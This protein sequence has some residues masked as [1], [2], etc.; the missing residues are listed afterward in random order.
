MTTFVTPED[1]RRILDGYAAEGVT[2][3]GHTPSEPAAAARRD[4]VPPP[5]D[6]DAPPTG[7]H[8][9]RNGQA[10]KPK[11]DGV[12]IVL[13][14]AADVRPERVRWAW[15]GRIPAG[16]VT[17]MVGKPK[18]GKSTIACHVVAGLSRGTLDGDLLG[19]PLHVVF[20]SAEDSTAHTLVPRLIAARADLRRVHF[21]TLKRDGVPDGIEL[22]DDADRL[23]AAVERV[24]AGVIVVDPLAA[25]LAGGVDSHRDAPMRRAM[26]PLHRMAEERGVTSIALAHTNKGQ[27]GDVHDRTGGSRAM[28]AA[29]RSLLLA[30]EHPDDDGSCVLV[31]AACNVGVEAPTLRYRVT[32][33]PIELHDRTPG[34]AAA[35]EWLGEAPE[36]RDHTVL[37]TRADDTEERSARVT[38]EAWLRDVLAEGPV[39]AKDVRRLAREDGIADRTLDRAKTN[40]KVQSKREGGLGAEGKWMWSL[41]DDAAIPNSANEPLSTPPPERG[42]DSVL[43]PDGGDVSEDRED[44]SSRRPPAPRPRSGGRLPSLTADERGAMTVAR[45][46][47]ARPCIRCRRP[48]AMRLADGQPHCMDCGDTQ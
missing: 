36:V 34:E 27:G 43:R 30:G 23:A 12:E 18:V 46:G 4:D 28:T 37:A 33:Q 20:L 32:S 17:L 6:A 24:N 13:T 21:L 26:A 16:M 5:G 1:Q 15:A 25:H 8:P 3:N 41:P 10:G 40:A 2:P 39:A 38:T 47:I 42:G 29:P 7:G 19:E 14:T 31:H 35:I 22:P 45:D 9:R 44:L 11:D 48:S